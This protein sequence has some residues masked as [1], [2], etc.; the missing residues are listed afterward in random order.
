MRGV[1]QFILIV[2]TAVR[3]E[4]FALSKQ[5]LSSLFR[6]HQP[7]QRYSDFSFPFGEPLS[8]MDGHPGDVFNPSKTELFLPLCL[9]QYFHA[10]PADPNGSPPHY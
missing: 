8:V 6:A 9:L 10:F 1:I 5:W 7:P 3:H 4:N 2:V